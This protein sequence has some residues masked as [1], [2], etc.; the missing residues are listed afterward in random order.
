MLFAAAGKALEA[1]V[2]AEFTVTVF[3]AVNTLLVLDWGTAGQS[4]D[5]H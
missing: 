2:D 4:S 1:D 5:F 3:K